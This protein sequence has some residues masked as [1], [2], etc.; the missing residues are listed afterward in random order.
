MRYTH[1]G[2]KVTFCTKTLQVSKNPSGLTKEPWML[3][4]SNQAKELVKALC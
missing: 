1:E 2:H 4:L 3:M